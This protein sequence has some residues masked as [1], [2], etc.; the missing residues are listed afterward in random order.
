MMR[1][2]RERLLA[3]LVASVLIVGPLSGQTIDEHYVDGKV[4]LKLSRDLPAIVW[5]GLSTE[6]GITSIKQPFRT[7][8]MENVY[9]IHFSKKN[10]ING[11]LEAFGKNPEVEYVE[12]VP[13]YRSTYTPDD[14]ASQQWGLYKIEAERTW[15]IARGDPGIVIGVI[16][17]AFRSDHEDLAPQIWVN[18][19]EIPGDGMDNDNNGFIDDASG[20]DVADDDTDVNPPIMNSIGWSHGSHV[21]GIASASTDNSKGVASIGFGCSILPIKAKHDTTTSNAIDASAEGIDYAIVSGAKVINMS[22]AGFGFSQTTQSL[23]NLGHFA[24][25]VWV[26]GAGNDGQWQGRFPAGYNHVISVGS[27]EQDDRKSGFSSYHPTVDVMAPGGG[28]WSVFSAGTDA[29]TFMSGT[30]MASPM[31]AGLCGLLLSIN[32]TMDPDEVQ[33][34]LKE[35]CVNID[36]LNPDYLGWIGAGRINALNSALCV[37]RL[38][39][40]VADLSYDK[41]TVCAG[42][43]VHFTDQSTEYPQHWEWD[44]GDGSS[45]TSIASATHVYTSPGTYTVKLI[46]SNNM[47]SDTIQYVAAIEV[48]PSPNVSVTVNLGAPGGS[49]LLASGCS[50]YSWTPANYLSCTDC[51]NP[52]ISPIVTPPLPDH[53]VTCTN[54]YGCTDSDTVFWYQLVSND[55]AHYNPIDLNPLY[56]NPTEGELVLSASFRNPGDLHIRLVD[57]RG[58]EMAQLYS[59]RTGKE[60]NKEVNLPDKVAAGMYLV[61]WNHSEGKAVQR[62]LV[63]PR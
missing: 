35:G 52:F 31:V 43:P 38:A 12:K 39:A 14:L 56:P 34:C 29:Y 32:P 25:I 13:L 24:G 27:T 33:Q 16:D 61:E 57:L 22:F 54:E 10:E 9:A 26:A 51:A 50:N 23:I 47:G 48:L 49:N 2:I 20:Y 42:Q 15:D 37:P 36:S 5:D 7:P 40:P 60:F 63:R 17:N 8:G 53:I 30:S 6:Y 18:P 1:R 55:P 58:K 11:L 62:L 4:Y 28:I 45:D 41:D 46:V 44:F 21:A 19:N 59:G 3:F